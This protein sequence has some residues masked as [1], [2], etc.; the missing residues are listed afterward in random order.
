[1]AGSAGKGGGSTTLPVE[2]QSATGRRGGVALGHARSGGGESGSGF[3]PALSEQTRG[4]QRLYGTGVWQCRPGQPIRV[5]RVAA[6]PLIGGPHMS[7]LF[8]F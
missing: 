8:Q 4:G 6:K 3:R 5:R 2:E 1:V 7:A